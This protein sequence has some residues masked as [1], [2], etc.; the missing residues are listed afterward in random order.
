MLMHLLNFRIARRKVPSDL[1]FSSRVSKIEE[2]KYLS[3]RIKPGDDAIFIN[4]NYRTR[5]VTIESISREIKSTKEYCRAFDVEIS[6]K[7]KK[8]PAFCIYFGA[9][10]KICIEKNINYEQFEQIIDDNK[11]LHDNAKREITHLESRRPIV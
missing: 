7:N 6:W 4:R 3:T 8:I 5:R 11:K 10:G 1:L 9:F 2:V